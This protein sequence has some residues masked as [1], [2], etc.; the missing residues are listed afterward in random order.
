MNAAFDVQR[1]SLIHTVVH[2]GLPPTSQFPPCLDPPILTPWL[3]FCGPT[4]SQATYAAGK[5][6]N[7]SCPEVE[8]PLA[9]G[10]NKV[11][12]A[13][14]FHVEQQGEPLFGGT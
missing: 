1:E 2:A 3:L 9:D 6:R 11:R 12:S 8:I 7:K 14:Y 5:L 4:D 13:L 10:E